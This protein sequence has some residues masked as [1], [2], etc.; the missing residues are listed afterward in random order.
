VFFDSGF[1]HY[2]HHLPPPDHLILNSVRI[3]SAVEHVMNTWRDQECRPRMRHTAIL[4]IRHF[5][6]SPCE[7][8]CSSEVLSFS[9]GPSGE[10]EEVRK[11]QLWHVVEK[12]TRQVLV[13]RVALRRRET[14]PRVGGR[15]GGVPVTRSRVSRSLAAREA[16]KWAVQRALVPAKLSGG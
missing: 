3:E 13:C 14:G 6:N 15:E 5:R 9:R 4:T 11:W 7:T 1:T 2:P 10:R 12:C 8:D 16:E